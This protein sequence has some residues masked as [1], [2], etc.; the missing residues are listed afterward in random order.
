VDPSWLGWETG[1]GTRTHGWDWRG[2]KGS[3]RLRNSVNIRSMGMPIGGA[4][5]VVDFDGDRLAARVRAQ[6]GHIGDDISVD[7]AHAKELDPVRNTICI[8][9]TCHRADGKPV[10]EGERP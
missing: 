6:R 5:H 9:I 3:Y 10:V 4:V 2:V 7:I 1:V 8:G